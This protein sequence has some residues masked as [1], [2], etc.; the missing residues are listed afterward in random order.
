MRKTATGQQQLK[1]VYPKFKNAEATVRN[2]RVEPNFG[3]S[4]C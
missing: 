4:I 3:K 2:V 1:I